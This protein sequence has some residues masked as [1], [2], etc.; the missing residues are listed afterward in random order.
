[1]L[2]QLYRTDEKNSH[3]ALN[4]LTEQFYSKYGI[5]PEFICTRPE[6]ISDHEIRV[7]LEKGYEDVFISVEFREFKALIRITKSVQLFDREYWFIFPEDYRPRLGD[8]G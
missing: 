5:L 6:T 4:A 1:M 8:I 7:A 2:G 3:K